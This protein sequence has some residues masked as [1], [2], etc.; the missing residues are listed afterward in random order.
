M[1]NI[2]LT[3]IGDELMDKEE[4][5]DEAMD[6]FN[7]DEFEEALEYFEKVTKYYPDNQDAWFM[8]AVTYINLE[9]DEKALQ[10]IEKAIELNPED[11]EAWV[12][13]AWILLLLDDSREGLKAVEKAMELDKDFTDVLY[14][15]G[16]FLLNMNL[17]SESLY[18]FEKYPED[19]LLYP[20]SL[21]QQ[22]VALY[23]LGKYRDAI[24]CFDESLKIE[25]ENPEVLNYKG[26][27]FMSLKDYPNARESFE[28]SLKFNPGFILPNFNLGILEKETK[29]FEQSIDYFEKVLKIDP[30]NYDAWYQ[31]GIIFKRLNLKK[32]SLDAYKKFIEIV[33]KNDIS[34]SKLIARRVK[35]YISN[36]EKNTGPVKLNPRK[37][38]VHWQWVLKPEDF[39]E[40]DGRERKSLEPQET[41]QP[42]GWWNC[43][44]ETRF[45]DLILIYR[46]GKKEGETYQDLKYLLM[47]TSDAYS[48][49]DDEYAFEHGLTYGCD[50][51]PL[52]KFE[53]PIALNEMKNEEYLE[54]WN[55]LTSNFNRLVY[56]TD[57]RHWD[58]LIRLLKDRNPD[59]E[60]ENLKINKIIE[61]LK[62]EY[63]LV[64]ALYDNIDALEKFGFNLDNIDRQVICK[65]PGGRIDIL[66]Y[67]KTGDFVVI[68]L[69]NDSANKSTYIQISEYVDW[70]VDRLANKESVK[71]LVISRGYDDEFKAAMDDS[72]NILHVELIDVLTELG[73]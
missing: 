71:G 28:K 51:Q 1:L 67:D 36:I 12:K 15:K 18:Y 38:P 11:T 7:N 22:G 21:F 14:L 9:E 40:D 39:L 6:F 55:A 2:L 13:K 44:K 47:A 3:L 43:H 34:E 64:E 31:K 61:D 54:G 56:K 33:K 37:T 63:G 48:I 72:P 24:T 59:F 45:G 50:Y 42:G 66:A 27:A 73:L 60:I 30:E 53:N 62:A 68:E 17:Y 65:G 32:E 46:A 70:A 8:K 10:S 69:K 4:Y 57:Q 26:L 5:F 35:E 52:F 49:E 16:M 29:N 58:H 25:S 23:K 41:T 19:E 20:D